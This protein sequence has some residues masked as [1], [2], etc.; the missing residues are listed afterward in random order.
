[1]GDTVNT[2]LTCKTPQ[3]SG[4]FDE[5]PGG[6]GINMI[7]DNILTSFNNLVN[8]IPSQNAQLS[9]IDRLS[10]RDNQYRDV[11]IWFK[12]Y[13]TPGKDSNYEFQ[14]ET[15]GNAVLLLSNDSSSSNKVNLILNIWFQ[16]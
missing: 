16:F 12:G 10:F 6:R 7:R 14:L 13:I 1:M 4:S 15:N 11:T 3:A 5:Y 8:A 9:Y 2:K